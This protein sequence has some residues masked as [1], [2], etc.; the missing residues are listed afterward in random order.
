MAIQENTT[1]L[2]YKIWD[3]FATDFDI[4]QNIEIINRKSDI[5]FSEF[6]KM[7]IWPRPWTKKMWNDLDWD[8]WVFSQ[9]NFV[10]F[11]K[12]SYHIKTFDKKVWYLD[13]DTWTDLWSSFSTTNIHINTN[14]LPMNLDG[15]AATT[16]TTSAEATASEKVKKDDNDNGWADNI[17]KYLII[18]EDSNNK[19]IFRWAFALIISYDDTDKEYTL[20]GSGILT[21]LKSGAKYQI[22]DTL[23][24]YIQFSTWLDYE[25]YYFGKSDWTLVRND[26]F[27]WL[28]TKWLR[29]VKALKD[30]E[31]LVKNISFSNTIVTFNK[32]TLF[33]SNWVP[34]NPFFYAITNSKTIPSW[35]P[36]IITDLFLFKDSLII[37]WESY[38]A[39]IKWSI[40]TWIIILITKTYWI[41]PWTLVDLWN[42]S[43]FISTTYKIY[44]LKESVYTQALYISDEWKVMR[45]YLNKFR[46]NIKGWFN[47]DK[48]FFYWE[49]EE[50]VIWTIIVYDIQYKFWSTYT[51]L[52]MSNIVLIDWKTYIWDNNSDNVRV[53]DKTLKK[54]LDV[55][56]NQV[57]ST[58]EIDLD[59]AFSI[60]TLSNIYLWLDNYK[61]ELTLELYAAL[62]LQNSKL[63]NKTIKLTEEEVNKNSAVMWDSELWTWIIWWQS[64]TDNITL[65]VLK[66]IQL[67]A[68]NAYFWKI[69]LKNKNEETFYLNEIGFAIILQNDNYF[70]PWDTI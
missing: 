50:W 64:Q 21:K 35:I 18:T 69:I 47:W 33:Y 37:G 6:N 19:N 63:L 20:S 70:S 2:S 1:Y 12:K 57:I 46:K 17:G 30:T 29:V 51:W 24:E 66:N 7:A 65:P 40:V 43:F 59:R 36:W 41:I 16:F 15:S 14:K 52:P 42:D 28:S 8:G 22:Y 45:N 5:W 67:S 13:W 31:F 53:F 4:L 25:E 10:D 32:N 49:E 11:Y 44:S 56:I 38:S 60:K 55:M 34:N 39:Y 26:T 61:Q 68:D 48:I 9:F 3:K 62:S 27:T 54:D 23:W 58:K